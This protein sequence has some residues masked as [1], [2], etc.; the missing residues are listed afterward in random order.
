ME[1]F[2]NDDSFVEEC[3]SDQ[4]S[5]TMCSGETNSEQNNTS[6]CKKEQ[7]NLWSKK[8]DAGETSQASSTNCEN[9]QSSSMNDK[10]EDWFNNIDNDEWDIYFDDMDCAMEPSA[11]RKRL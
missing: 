1:E 4:N 3:L 8:T 2:D 6:G 11:K 9:N 5:G 10:S 7:T